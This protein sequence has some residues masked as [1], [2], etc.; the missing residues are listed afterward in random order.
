[1]KAFL[2]LDIE[3]HDLNVFRKYASEIPAFVEKHS[4]QYIVLGGET[5]T[6]EGNWI[7]QRLVVI[8]FPSKENAKGFLNDSDAQSIFALRH[9]STTSKLVLVEGCTS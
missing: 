4:G 1:M 3:I 9:K 6:I 5:E 2:I 8:E 7:P